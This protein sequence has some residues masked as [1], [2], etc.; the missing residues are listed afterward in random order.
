M[1]LKKIMIPVAMC[2]I[3]AGGVIPSFA[4]NHGDTSFR[5]TANPL[6][7]YTGARE[8]QDASSSYLRCTYMPSG[9]E[10]SASVLAVDRNGKHQPVASPIY[11]FRNGTTKYL[12]N[13][14]KENSY[15]KACI[16]SNPTLSSKNYQS[17][18][19]WSPDS[20]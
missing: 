16:V 14:V 1:K 18:G 20:I 9:Y 13:Y 6:V 5:F 17:K 3:L 8:K 12:A 19:V 10:A 2:M 7:Q 11:G 4:N 15:R